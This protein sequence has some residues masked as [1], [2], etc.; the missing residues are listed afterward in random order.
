MF[1]FFFVK[2]E[3]VILRSVCEM[4]NDHFISVKRDEGPLDPY[5]PL[6]S[7]G[8]AFSRKLTRRPSSPNAI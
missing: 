2:R 7:S 4:G 5:L 8:M 6:P 3:M 1:S